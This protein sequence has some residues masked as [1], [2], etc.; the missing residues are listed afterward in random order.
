MYVRPDRD[1]KCR[2]CGTMHDRYKGH[3]I[4]CGGKGRLL[5]V[6]V[7]IVGGVKRMTPY[8]KIGEKTYREPPRMFVDVPG[9]NEVSNGGIPRGIRV[10]LGGVPGCGKTTLCAQ[11]AAAWTYGAVLYATGEESEQQAGA[12]FARLGFRHTSHVHLLETRDVETIVRCAD[13]IDASL[14]VVDSIQKAH[15]DNCDGAARG[16]AQMMYASDTLG[17]QIAVKGGR[18]LALISQVNKDDSLNGS[19]DLEHMGDLVIIM[20]G[21]KRNPHKRL[22][23]QKTRFGPPDSMARL[24]MTAKGLVDDTATA[25]DAATQ[26]AMR[27]AGVREK[28]AP[29]AEAEG[30][31]PKRGWGRKR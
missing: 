29:S 8:V 24:L 10:V 31:A 2:D 17:D 25:P 18:T 9:I 27:R 11:I 30:G 26:E 16:P 12:R 3:C 23:L 21:G 6:A 19:R 5:P 20:E 7:Q 13:E 28:T 22:V 14:V 1:Y 4:G 15:S